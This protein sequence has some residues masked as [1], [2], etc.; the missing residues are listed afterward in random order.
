MTDTIGFK[1]ACV[2]C[3]ASCST[4]EHAGIATTA[5]AVELSAIRINAGGGAIVDSAGRTWAADYAFSGGRTFAT[6]KPIDGTSDDK[7]FQ[8]ERWGK[9]FSYAVNV[10]TGDYDVRLYFAEIFFD[11]PGK[12]VFDIQ[13]EGVTVRSQF[14]V[15]DVVPA[16][17]AVVHNYAVE[18]SDGVLNVAFVPTV[19]NAKLS[20]M[21]VIAR[22]PSSAPQL[23]LQPASHDFGS[24]EL[25]QSSVAVTLHLENSGSA[26]LNVSSVSL[27]GADAADFSLSAGGGLTIPPGGDA[28][29]NASF[30]PSSVGHRE[31]LVEIASDDPLGPSMVSLAGQGVS[32][33]SERTVI[34]INAGGPG[35]TDHQGNAWQADAHF[36]GG[37]TYPSVPT[38]TPITLTENDEVYQSERW[39]DPFGYAIDVPNG[40]YVVDLHF[41][42]IFHSAPGKRIFDV[43]IE[44]VLRDDDLDIFATV[45][46][47]AAIV[48]SHS[49]TVSDGLLN[50]DLSATAN[51]GKLSGIE[52]TSVSGTGGGVDVSPVALAFGPVVAGESTGL[53]VAVR[54][55]G[56]DTVTISDVHIVGSDAAVF[57]S[58]FVVPAAIP[59]GS[60][61][62]FP[63]EFSSTSAGTYSAELE[64]H[65][66][67]HPDV[68]V[69]LSGSATEAPSNGFELRLNA[70]GPEYTDVQGHTWLSDAAY[71]NAT[72]TY[73][74]GNAIGGTE[75]DVLYQTERFSNS[76]AYQIPVPSGDHQV[77][78]HFAEIFHNASGKRIFDIAIEGQLVAAKLDIYDLVGKYNSLSLTYDTTVV[79]GRL[80]IQFVTYTDNAKLSAV[81]VLGNDADEHE[82]PFLHVVTNAPTWLVDYDGNNT[83]PVVLDGAASH[84]HELGHV[85]NSFSWHEGITPLGSGPVVTVDLSVGSHHITQTIADDNTP[86]DTLSASH[87]I[88][89]Y[90]IN[91][92]GGGLAKFYQAT[93]SDLESWLNAP[94]SV[95]DYVE[96]LPE[97]R[98][99]QLSG[100]IGNSPFTENAVVV[101]TADLHAVE[102]GS[103]D[104]A[105]SGAANQR[106]YIDGAEVTGA[107]SL[108]TGTYA[109]ELR[110][111]VTDA[112]ELPI[113][114][115][116]RVDGGAAMPLSVLGP[117]HSHVNLKPFINS[118]PDIGSSAGGETIEIRG[119]GF[120]TEGQTS[121]HW[122]STQLTP[123]NVNPTRTSLEVTVPPGTGSVSV[124]VVTP[125]GQSPA[126]TYNYSGTFTPIS[127][128][129]ADIANLSKPTRIAFG[130]DGRI[131]VATINGNIAIYT[132]DDNYQVTATQLV[133]TIGGL[134]N[135]NILGLAFH[136]HEA[137]GPV[138]IYVAHGDLFANGGSCFT[139]FSPYSGQVSVLQGPTFA[140]ATPLI[141]S[142][143]V[144]NHDHGVNGIEFDQHGDLYVAIGGNTNAG[145]RHCKLGDVPESPLSG[146]IVK[147][148]ITK[149]GFNGTIQY[150][151]TSGGGFN[152]DQVFGGSVDVAPGVDVD[153]FAPGLR[154]PFDLVLSTNGLL[155]GTD[156]GPNTSFGEASTSATTQGP[157]VMAPDEVMLL[158]SGHYYG[159]PNRNRGRTDSRQNVYYGPDSSEISGRY[160]GPLTIV[161][162]SS[163]D[164][165]EYRATNFQSQLRGNLLVQR[166]NKP[167]YRLE[168]SDSG[169]GLD[170]LHTIDEAPKGLSIATAPAGVI[171]G[172]DY[173]G[174]K[175]TAMFPTDGATPGFAAFDLHPWRAPTT[176]GVQFTIGGKGFGTVTNTNVSFGDVPAT[177]TS[178]TG[179]RIR[180]LVPTPSAP[181][182]DL[183]D[184]VVSSGGSTATI[185]AAFRYLLPPG[186]GK[187]TWNTGTS[188]P[189]QLGEV[190]GGVIRGVL[191]LVG[192]GPPATVGYDF[193][194]GRWNTSA[195]QRPF[196]GHHH[197]AEVVDDK[198]YVLGGLGHGSNGKLQ[199]F[200]PATNHWS[201][202][203]DLP[204]ATGAASSAVIDGKIYVAGGIVGSSTTSQAAVYDPDTDMW[205]LIAPMPL[206]RNHA[207]SATDG[208][209]L[210][211]FG[212]RG[213]GS[214]NG[215]T[216]AVGF[217]DVQ[218]YDPGTNTWES[219]ASNATIPALPQKRGGTGKAVYF[220]G[221]FYVIGGETT[222]A[223]VGQQSGNVYDRVDVYNAST[224]S[225]RLETPLP[226]ARHGIFPVLVD[227]RIVVAGG[228]VQAGFSAS[229]VLEIFHR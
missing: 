204:F 27:S 219:N 175:V 76:L 9:P 121:V 185:P 74:T 218:I 161:K 172:A 109:L 111:A 225:W 119:V 62:S 201:L 102:A 182:A 205:S 210:F 19:Q 12:R 212:G 136:P 53:T 17:T 78:L 223:G 40:D 7:I 84:T 130:P 104:L 179:T 112:T 166:W 207:A 220:R 153:V 154:N 86:P 115:S 106:L 20:G 202:G 142:L 99:Q 149:L 216:V 116:V 156:N 21:E 61:V 14:D 199:I 146:A 47:Y 206:G 11:Q 46:K 197:A 213:A 148:R 37:R 58:D 35:F 209:R 1:L 64:L 110:V 54:N 24:V 194:S 69:A 30:A 77:T 192:E 18:V 38:S 228:G 222:S 114:V 67:A 97:V 178:V 85:L 26:P 124:S 88:D 214:G 144:S 73:T 152:S 183:L 70:G 105:V 43:S 151:N 226:T 215:N 173:T 50:I 188:M 36:V 217:D 134:S 25:G 15:L 59:A 28:H 169:R 31:A 174:N 4:T 186:Q 22:T 170:T 56:S 51:A 189:I 34:R 52:V 131:Y 81:A 164:I 159:H 138:R 195:A 5:A 162:S 55:Q 158:A 95:P 42:E 196:A 57:S 91:A 150:V 87:R 177:I 101:I 75:D 39:G 125:R 117:T 187:G 168:L 141:T 41:A 72:R 224:Q 163:N 208:V 147:A 221:E 198:L 108:S 167:L 2:V 96:V 139:G 227:N 48:R 45:G 94:P 129:K 140:V 180:G 80:D 143:P 92:V 160:T 10:P 90:P 176:G 137:A 71:A 89:V 135:P 16:F 200:D 181:T 79:D 107:V 155:Y 203:A 60:T 29:I 211:V 191:Y 82:H 98:L 145:V 66:D 32:S 133:N 3:M 123:T 100:R 193:V 122:G 63:I 157:P 33:S 13:I 113:D 23:M 93:A 120:F 49:V 44:G 229:A 68:Q 8:S 6:Q 65:F 171:L 132:V 127:F 190:A 126:R 118:M 83:E 103:Y 128:D 165:E 184:V